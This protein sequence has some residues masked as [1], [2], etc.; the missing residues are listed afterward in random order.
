MFVIMRLVENFHFEIEKEKKI[1]MIGISY[2][3]EY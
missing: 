1:E 2:T 3:V